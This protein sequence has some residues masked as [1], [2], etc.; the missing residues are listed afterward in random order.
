MPG[1]VREQDTHIGHASPCDPF[2]QTQYV[3]AL[4][5]TVY[6]N[7]RLAIVKGDKT[8]CNDPAVGGSSSVFIGGIGVHMKGDATGGHPADSCGENWFPNA[9]ETASEDVFAA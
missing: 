1:I 7:D 3:A 4:N 5:T 2:H 6:V 9:S 8:G